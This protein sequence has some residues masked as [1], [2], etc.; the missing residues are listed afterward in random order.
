MNRRSLYILVAAVVLLLLA[1]A[2][3]VLVRRGREEQVQ[4]PPSL[5][6]AGPWWE[7]AFTTP[8]RTGTPPSGSPGRL[9]ERL[10]ALIDGAQRSVDIA[11]YDFGLENVADA[12]IRA[13]NRGVAVRIVTDTDNLDNRPIERV[14]D[15]GIAVVDDQ[16]RAIMHHKF[17][18][19]DGET[20]LTGAWN[21][22]ERDTFRHNNNTAVFRSPELARNFS[23]EFEKMFTLRR[24]G[25]TKPKDVPNPTVERDSTTVRTFFASQTPVPPQ[26]LARIQAAQTSIAFMAFTFT[27]DDLAAALQEK[28]RGGVGLWG[29]F[30]TTGSET[31]FSEFR[32]LSAVQN[33]T[34]G[35]PF[36]GCS[37]GPSMV[38]DGNPFLMH[39]KVFVIDERTVIFGSFNFTAAAAEDNDEA[40]LI[41][42]DPRMARAFLDEFCRVYNAGVEK[43]KGSR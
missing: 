19:I 42:D 2:V 39:H 15:A 23:N 1:A 21:F 40:L 30:E 32:T 27:L 36:P 3:V 24:F 22:A 5:P 18:V 31:Q 8:Q 28:A 26:I 11:I 4:A 35:P 43:A 37:D 33:S 9:D 12:A 20:L 7:V 38:Q 16:R 25:P 29:V 14:R 10:V 13:K 6:T 41:V 17:A 34:K